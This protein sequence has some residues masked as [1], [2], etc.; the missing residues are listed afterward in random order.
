MPQGADAPEAWA[1]GRS[2]KM[3]ENLD[4]MDYQVLRGPDKRGKPDTRS[5]TTMRRT[6]YRTVQRKRAIPCSQQK[7]AIGTGQLDTG[8]RHG[9]DHHLG[10]MHGTS[11]QPAEMPT[12]TLPGG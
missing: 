12:P 10:T 4:A 11:G 6:L 3:G 7:D 2:R 8:Q 9:A 5:W 1:R